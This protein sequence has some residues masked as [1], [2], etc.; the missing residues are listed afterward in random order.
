MNAKSNIPK[1]K[2]MKKTRELE[3]EVADSKSSGIT[4]HG[5]FENFIAHLKK[6]RG[7]TDEQRGR[8]MHRE[9]EESKA[10]GMIRCGSFENFIACLKQTMNA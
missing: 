3:R 6:L 7:K 2:I 9:A 1:I 10:T 8:R 5:S 4:R